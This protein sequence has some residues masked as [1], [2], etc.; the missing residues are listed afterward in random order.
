MSQRRTL[1]L[2]SGDAEPGDSLY[3]FLKVFLK[4]ASQTHFHAED[5]TLRIFYGT[6]AESVPFF[7]FR[8]TEDTF[9]A[10]KSQVLRSEGA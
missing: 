6:R 4:T 5:H 3:G 9:L 2:L 8:T 1:R 10:F 7:Y